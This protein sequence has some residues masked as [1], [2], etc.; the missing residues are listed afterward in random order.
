[1]IAF[2]VRQSITGS[3]DVNLAVGG[4]YDSGAFMFGDIGDGVDGGSAGELL[5]ASFNRSNFGN[6]LQAIRDGVGTSVAPTANVKFVNATWYEAAFTWTPTSGRTGNFSITVKN[7]SDNN[8]LYSLATSSPFT[9][10]ADDAYFAFG[11]I[12]ATSAT[13]D[14]ISITGTLVPEPASL[15]LLGLGLGLIGRRRR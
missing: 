9:F 13:F 4:N 14:N 11:D 12:D 5:Y 6:D 1:M 15:G 2:D 8:T 7:A 3:F 10:A